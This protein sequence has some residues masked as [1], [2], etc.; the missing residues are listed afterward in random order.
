MNGFENLLKDVDP[1]TMEKGVER[2]TAF[3]KTAEGK[4]MI[5]KLKENMP[6]DKDAL[7][8]MLAQNPELMKSVEKFFKK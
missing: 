3:A 7:M 2:A 1:K 5:E 4:A 8:K 6:A